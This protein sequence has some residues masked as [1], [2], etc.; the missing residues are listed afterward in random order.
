MVALL[1]FLLALFASPLRSK[2]D[3]KRIIK[4]GGGSVLNICTTQSVANQSAAQIPCYHSL[5]NSNVSSKLL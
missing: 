2:S 4:R 5:T 1:C 3:L